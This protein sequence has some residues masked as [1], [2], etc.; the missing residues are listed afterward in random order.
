INCAR[1]EYCAFQV[2]VQAPAGGLANI[3]FSVSN[4]TGRG[5]PSIP[6]TDLIVYREQYITVQ[7]HSP[8]WNGPPNLPIINQNTFPYP[9][10]PFIDPATGLPPS[11][12]APYV[13][14]PTNLATGNNA[15]FWV[16][17]YVPRGTKAGLYTGTYTVSSAQGSVS[18]Q[19]NVCVWNFTL[20]LKT[21]LHTNFN[22]GNVTVTG[23]NAEMMRN[24][25]MPD[26][27]PTRS[28]AN[29]I[30]QYGL[31]IVDLGFFSGVNFGHCHMS[32]PPSVSTIHAAE[33]KQQSG[34]NMRDYSAD[35]ES[36]CAGSRYYNRMMNCVLN[37]DQ[38]GVNNLASQQPVP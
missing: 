30:A 31:N 7:Q 24:R 23:G 19:I 29:D 33:A 26:Q 36:S 4:L 8:T 27:D 28:Q 18:G 17:T 9:L 21:S 3:N 35:P 25:L 13:A 12:G 14:A 10:V 16:D 2:A 11:S 20:P 1:G 32:T 34:L 6:S 15:I 22:G 5:R 38:A 37:L